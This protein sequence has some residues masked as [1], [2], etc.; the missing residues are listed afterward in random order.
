MDLGE[1]GVR[2]PWHW[3]G[4]EAADNREQ[5]HSAY[6]Q[7]GYDEFICPSNLRN[8]A[9][10]VLKW[11]FAHFKEEREVVVPP[12]DDGLTRCLLPGSIVYTQPTFCDWG[13]AAKDAQDRPCGENDAP[14]LRLFHPMDSPL[15][16]PIILMTGQSDW[17]AAEFCGLAINPDTQTAHP[18][19][20]HWFAQN[21]NIKP[22]PAFSLLPIGINCFEMAR[23]LRHLLVQRYTVWRA[24][25]CMED[26]AALAGTEGATLNE[27]VVSWLWHLDREKRATFSAGRVGVL[28]ALLHLS[29]YE[30]SDEVWRM[31]A[32][33]NLELERRQKDN[34]YSFVRS[35]M[36]ARNVQPDAPKDHPTMPCSVLASAAAR[37]PSPS[38]SS[39]S[40]SSASFLYPLNVRNAHLARRNQ[41]DGK[42]AIANFGMTHPRREE[43][44]KALCAGERGVANKG[45]LTCRQHSWEGVELTT[46]YATLSEYLYWVSPRGN[47]LES[48]RTW[49]ALYLGCVPVLER[50]EVTAGLFDDGDLPVLLVDDLT[51]LT[52][53]VLLEHLPRFE[54]IERDFPRRKLVLEY[55]KE[56][57]VRKQREWRDEWQKSGALNLTHLDAAQ[58]KEMEHHRC[59][60]SSSSFR[61]N[62]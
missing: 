40:S 56:R 10:Y 59:W 46:H 31:N 15:H 42:L 26:V 14:C 32:R 48:H 17:A 36:A 20:I 58:V 24:E 23:Q 62:W 45:W 52:R 18:N 30:H 25:Q 8:L 6:H 41:P 22:H 4:G 54:H 49:E 19:L 7:Q 5:V 16:T 21:G 27:A 39:S 12:W 55:W 51:A 37:N 2:C 1:C 9:D 38:S 13:R 33:A 44:V 50:S 60:G 35:T 43:V 61:E 34:D 47:G 57:V 28:H 53:E 3:R 11:P 29:R